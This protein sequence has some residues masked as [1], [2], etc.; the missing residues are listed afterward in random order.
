MAKKQNIYGKTNLD[1]DAVSASFK[2]AIHDNKT[3]LS[4]FEIYNNY[5]NARLEKQGTVKLT[6]L[7]VKSYLQLEEIEFHHQGTQKQAGEVFF[8][9]ANESK[10]DFKKRINKILIEQTKS[11]IE[12]R[13]ITE[14]EVNYYKKKL[15]KDIVNIFNAA[16]NKPKNYPRNVFIAT[17]D[18]KVNE[19]S[20]N[21][22]YTIINGLI[23]ENEFLLTKEEQ[24]QA[25]KDFRKENGHKL[26][27]EN[28]ANRFGLSSEERQ[29]LTAGIEK[30]MKKTLFSI[31][32]LGKNLA[33]K[34][35]QIFGAILKEG[36]NSKEIE[37]ILR[38]TFLR[39]VDVK[40]EDNAFWKYKG[41][42]RQTESRY[43]HNITTLSRTFSHGIDNLIN[44]NSAV[45]AGI[46]K[47]KYVGN[48]HPQRAF[49]QNIY[50]SSSNP[51]RV[52]TIEEINSM[53]NNQ[54]LDVMT[55]AGGYNCRH[56]WL[57]AR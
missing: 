50:N 48:P 57:P 32:V 20:D 56:Y 17:L 21:L 7:Q 16:S 46:S 4:L 53:N 25:L 37:K 29:E 44:F 39:K 15:Q 19:F 31:D 34:Y 18:K 9:K 1:N 26:F 8:S 52:Y 49:C 12:N 22:K 3:P 28:F 2:Q 40:R 23:R 27:A 33:K 43:N 13:M 45:E 54:G 14:R 38:D 47:F 11:K 35:T 42:V 36:A 5:I 10:T 6:I 41:K 51:N 24:K 55:F 30:V